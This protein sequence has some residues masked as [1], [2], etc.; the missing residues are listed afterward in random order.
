MKPTTVQLDT[1]EVATVLAALRLRQCNDLHEY[2]GLMDIATNGDTVE[3]LSDDEIDNLC[4]RI[5]AQ[6]GE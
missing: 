4:E 2:E 6:G 1:R 3:P 5:N